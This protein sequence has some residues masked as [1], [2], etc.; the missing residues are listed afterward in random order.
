MRSEKQ[1][2]YRKEYNKRYYARS[3]NSKR[4]NK[5][6]TEEEIRIVM[7]HEESDE[8]ISKKLQ[9]SIASIQEKRYREK[10][11]NNEMAVNADGCCGAE[12]EEYGQGH[13]AGDPGGRDGDPD[14]GRG[15]ADRG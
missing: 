4:C 14:D 12:V 6:W 15:G 9:R 10:K 2:I 8:V 3:A 11:K 1:K 5:V 13:C 7:A